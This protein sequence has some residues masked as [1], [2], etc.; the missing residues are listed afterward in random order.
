M[1]QNKKLLGSRLFNSNRQNLFAE[2]SGD[3]NPIHINPLEARKTL[4]GECIVHGIHAF[5]WSLELL[6]I[7][8]KGIFSDYDVVFKKFIPLNYKVYIYWDANK[9]ELTIENEEKF[10]LVRIKCKNRFVLIKRDNS[11]TVEHKKI[12][13][14][15]F[16][17]KNLKLLEGLHQKSIYGGNIKNAQLLFPTLC[18]FLGKYLVYELSIISNIVG[19]QCPGLNSL[20]TAC[21]FSLIR[22]ENVIPTFQIKSFN[23]KINYLKIIYNGKNIMSEMEAFITPKSPSSLI[24]SELKNKLKS[25]QIYKNK[26]VLIIGGSRG[27]GS[28]LAKIIALLG[29]KVTITYL[30][31]AKEAKE[32]SGDINLKVSTKSA[33][34]IKF[35]V[36]N[37]AY[38]EVFKFS[39][40]YLFYFATPKIF[41]EN[42]K[43][44]DQNVYSRFRQCYC[45]SFEKISK[46][47]ILEGGNN[48]FYPS[49]IAIDE[50]TK[51]LEEYILAKEEGEKICERLKKRHKKNIKF[52]RLP[53]IMTDQTL[54]ILPIKAQDPFNAALEI[55]NKM[56]D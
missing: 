9:K 17:Y 18:K 20:F 48:I 13:S 43:A 1:Q 23:Q 34:Y 49:S 42:K 50:Q 30:K 24:S 6:L 12:L 37:D 32:V 40:D 35:D 41:G 45:E 16:E 28:F 29:G 15:P 31:G 38:S 22:E 39:F 52:M 53:R 33:N 2:L 36:L 47:F 3:I 4:A 25:N 7:V 14:K 5:L 8:N 26:K 54:T 10:I 46:N 27:I 55:A 56:A 44:F 19:M 21:R 11:I 51:G